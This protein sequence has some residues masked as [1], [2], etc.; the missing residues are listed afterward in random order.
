MSDL[1]TRFER[2]SPLG[3]PEDLVLVPRELVS[4]AF[5][6][7]EHFV[8]GPDTHV[9]PQD[10]VD[11]PSYVVSSGKKGD[12]EAMRHLF[13]VVGSVVAFPGDVDWDET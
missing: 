8:L 5:D 13:E 9:M 7:V 12:I 2:I 11:E 6:V 3:N 4:A 10:Y 1:A